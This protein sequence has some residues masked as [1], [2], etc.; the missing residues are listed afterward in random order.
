MKL[1]KKIPTTNK[2]QETSSLCMLDRGI[3]DMKA[4]RDCRW[5]MLFAKSQN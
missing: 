4:G 5:K 3:D 2:S 1:T